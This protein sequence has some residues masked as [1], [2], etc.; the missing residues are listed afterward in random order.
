MDDAVPTPPRPARGFMLDSARGQES[1]AYYRRFIDFAAA[2]GMNTLLWHFTDD[3]GCSLRLDAVPGIASPDA[4][5]KAEMR[6]LVRYARDRGVDVVPELAS[7]GHSRYLTRLPAYRHLSE[8]DGAHF[9]GMCPVSHETRRVVRALIEEV[10]DVFDGPNLH[11][12]LDEVNIGGHPLTRAALRTRTRGDLLADYAT[13]VHSVVAG[14]GK[15]M[16][17]WGDGLLAHPEMLDRVP[18][19]VV[20]CNWQ[21]TPD[22]PPATTRT[23]LDA[24]FDVMLCSALISHDQPLFPGQRFAV[25]NVH[26]MQAQ[27]SLAGRGRVLGHVNTI[28]TP[29]RFIA[30][31]LWL[32]IDLTATA[33]SG[34][35][36]DAQPRTFGETL[37]GLTGD[38]AARFAEA[39]RL[40]LDGAPLREEW[41]A[42]A[43]MARLSPAALSRATV[44]AERLSTVQSLLVSVAPSVR[45]HAVEYRALALLVEVLAH[46]YNV[47]VRLA[48]RFPTPATLARLLDRS[49]TL[50]A[51]V[52]ADWDRERFADDPRKYVAPVP[53]FQDG[54]LIPLLQQGVAQLRAR[55]ATVPRLAAV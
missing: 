11:V 48:D 25:P 44:A 34:G 51:A 13:F 26:A 38:A 46:T 28:W 39:A 12:G 54:H 18:R 10:A 30:D 55:A 9:T 37:H 24:G 29:V 47:A 32:G 14:V 27:Q 19:A 1:R 45:L 5:T 4:Y 2:R 7:L 15:R 35:D 43:K 52:D 23:L 16:W 41:F 17:M 36:A 42:I 33:L 6:E 40:L 50:L 3:Q 22:A 53:S 31:S 21:Y 20:I 8:A 49:E